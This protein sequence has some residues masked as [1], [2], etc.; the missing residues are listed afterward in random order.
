MAT[1]LQILPGV[2]LVLLAA[3]FLRAGNGLLTALCLG[4]T[5]ALLFRRPLVARVAQAVLCLGAVEWGLTLR[6][7]LSERLTTG[8]PTGRL[9]TILGVV[10]FLTAVSAAVFESSALRR[11]YRL[12]AG[13]EETA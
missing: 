5:G 11:R 9:T 12:G 2:S 1:F 13:R 10:A 3:H 6:R 4:V 7:L 8:Q